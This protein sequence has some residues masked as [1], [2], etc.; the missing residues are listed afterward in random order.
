M[1][2]SLRTAC[3]FRGR[4][5]IAK[6]SASQNE[7]GNAPVLPDGDMKRSFRVAADRQ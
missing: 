1:D 3:E 4:G 7:P 5:E 6:H 2:K